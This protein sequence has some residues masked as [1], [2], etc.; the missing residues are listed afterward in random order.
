MW[1]LKNRYSASETL[2]SGHWN[3]DRAMTELEHSRMLCT[4]GVIL[5]CPQH[6]SVP[7]FR[8]A[9]ESI[10]AGEIWADCVLF[11][12]LRCLSWETRQWC[13][14]KSANRHEHCECWI[15]TDDYR[16]N[17]AF[18]FSRLFELKMRSYS[19]CVVWSKSRSWCRLKI[20][21]SK[22]H[23]WLCESLAKECALWV[24]SSFQMCRIGGC[25][26]VRSVSLLH[27]GKHLESVWVTAQPLTARLSMSVTFT[28]T[29]ENIVCASYLIHTRITSVTL[30]SAEASHSHWLWF[31]RFKHLGGSTCTGRTKALRCSVC[32][33]RSFMNC[34]L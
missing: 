5:H 14:T 25:S 32:L 23:V 1:L 30:I 6:F 21:T 19:T 3:C 20:S 17:I 29:C 28:I 18:F 26:R 24:L 31:T 27:V 2:S 9:G 33:A 8:S 15:Q 4:V 7:P 34:D 10:L 12:W 13:F 11:I 16:S 22:I